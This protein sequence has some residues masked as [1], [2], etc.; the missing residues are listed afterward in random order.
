MSTLQLKLVADW[1]ITARC[2]LRCDHC[3]VLELVSNANQRRHEELTTLECKQLVEFL[4]R[5]GTR[6]IS[7]TGGEALTRPDLFEIIDHAHKVGLKVYLY[8]TGLTFMNS[9]TRRFST[10]MARRALSRVDFLGISLDVYH[11]VA[12]ERAKQMDY[13]KRLINPLFDLVLSE[14]PELQIQLFTVMG[15][16]QPKSTVEEMLT[17]VYHAADFIGS[18][19]SRTKS[20]IRWRLS[21]LR[22]NPGSMLH[23]QNEL[24]F[25]AG[26]IDHAMHELQKRYSGDCGFTM[27]FGVDYDSFFIYPNGA[28]RTVVLDE[29]GVDHFIEL[30][31]FRDGVIK[32]QD[33][34]QELYSKD[35]KTAE[36]MKRKDILKLGENK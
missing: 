36:R 21:P 4:Y 24:V 35:G 34:W 33:I 29:E 7:I 31:N 9:M 22:F 3:I 8:T 11:D 2:P 14:F 30:G 16:Q 27:H 6:A 1:I 17:D 10:E 20:I 18:L 28:F 32:R 26:D 13:C 25:P 12:H 19:S 5:H 15:K 23:W